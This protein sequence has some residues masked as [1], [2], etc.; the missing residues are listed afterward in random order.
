M[1]NYQNLLNQAY[2]AF[3][4]RD[5]DAVLALMHPTVDWPNGWEGGYVHGHDEV[6]VY[7]IRQWQQLN[8][9]VTPTAFQ[10]KPGGEIEVEVHQV[11]RDLDGQLVADD[12]VRHTYTFAEGKIMKMVI[13]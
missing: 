10:F 11:V 9:K 7:W 5:I 8:P 3:N 2:E 4:A 13:D 6:R 12:Q 1:N